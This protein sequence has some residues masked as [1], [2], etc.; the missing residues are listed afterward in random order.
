MGIPRIACRHI[1]MCATRKADNEAAH[2]RIIRTAT[3]ESALT[4]A[5][6]KRR[7]DGTEDARL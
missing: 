4:S 6:L 2:R 1:T 3:T 7:K 5:I